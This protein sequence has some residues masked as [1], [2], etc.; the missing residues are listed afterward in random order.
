MELSLLDDNN[1]ISFYIIPDDNSVENVLS[2][3]GD[4]A[5]GLVQ[6][7]VSA[8][9]IE[10]GW[11]GSLT[12]IDPTDGYW[13][14]LIEAQT[15]TITGNVTDPNIEYNLLDGANLISFPFEGVYDIS[16]VIPDDVETNFLG[17][18]QLELLIRL[19]GLLLKNLFPHHQE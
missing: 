12:H 9:Q 8:A 2:V 11:I 3:F 14:K 6:E 17:V 7:G 18:I 13:I 5:I 1:L 4:N 15:V 10:T 19:L 16:A